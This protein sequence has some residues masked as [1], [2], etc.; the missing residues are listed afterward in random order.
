MNPV[1]KSVASVEPSSG[2]GRSD[3]VSPWRDLSRLSPARIGLGR[4][5][6]SLPTREI[7]AFGLAHARARD[8]VGAT[9]DVAALSAQL[10][11][12]GSQLISVNSC[13]PD[14]T[15]YLARPDWGRGLSADSAAALDALHLRC[16]LAF[17]LGDG[18]SSM[19]VQRHAGALLQALLPRLADLHIGPLVIATQ[20]RVALAD[21][22]A[23]RLA[24]RM[25]VCLIGE[26]PGLSSPESL[27][28]YLTWAPR[29]GRTDAERNCVSNIHEAGLSCEQAAS[30][31]ERLI[32]AAFS[33]QLTGVALDR[34]VV[35]RLTQSAT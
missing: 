25:L 33:L 10:E 9:L 29:V 34:A 5:G 18:L 27:G 22:I 30:E 13:A 15:A 32:R 8:A 35:P 12:L 26:R 17:V 14:R 11:R 19:A 7:L 2:P 24:A 1:P 23:E 4:S 31:L 3:G 28:A 20:A 21:E 16:D 6:V